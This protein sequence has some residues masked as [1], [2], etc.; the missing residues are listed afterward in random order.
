MSSKQ[1]SGVTAG[2]WQPNAPM[3][4]AAVGLLY[5]SPQWK[6]G[7]IDK[8][9]GPQYSDTDNLKYYKI[10]SYTNVT[11]TAGYTLP[12]QGVGSAELSVNVDNLLGTRNTTLITEANNNQAATSWQTSTD[13]YFFQAPRSVF[14]NLALRY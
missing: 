8:L 5:Q 14:V 7:L 3:W 6:F 4:T 1:T 2:N 12:V 13:Q 9:V 10:H 11:A